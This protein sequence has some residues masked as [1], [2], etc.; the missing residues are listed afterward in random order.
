MIILKDNFIDNCKLLHH[1]ELIESDD[2]F[3]T[4]NLQNSI[5]EIQ[6][7]PLY[8]LILIY[9]NEFTI[10]SLTFPK[11]IPPK[12]YHLH[13]YNWDNP[14][15]FVSLKIE[16]QPRE[17]E[18]CFVKRTANIDSKILTNI[19]NTKTHKFVWFVLHITESNNRYLRY[20]PEF[21]MSRQYLM[22]AAF[23]IIYDTVDLFKSTIKQLEYPQIKDYN[24]NYIDEC[25]YTNYN[26]ISVDISIFIHFLSKNLKKYRN[27]YDFMG[28]SIYITS[29]EFSGI[30][31]NINYMHDENAK[32][33]ISNGPLIG[34]VAEYV[35]KY[36]EIEEYVYVNASYLICVDEKKIN[37]IKMIHKIYSKNNKTPHS[38]KFNGY[39]KIENY[40]K[41]IEQMEV[42]Q[43]YKNLL[44]AALNS[45]NYEACDEHLM[46]IKNTKTNQTF[47]IYEIMYDNTI[48]KY[49]NNDMILCCNKII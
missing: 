44:Y 46:F 26:S 28:H 35:I 21:Y 29:R 20:T 1:M 15:P 19:N 37:I 42:S 23:T 14:L 4:Y 38:V 8:G 39:Y 22:T 16:Q 6:F 36:K 45:S 32:C 12:G 48:W 3:N 33:F 30:L 24:I 41:A 34:V 2:E 17:R 11:I 25:I 5:T 49:K 10:D 43:N 40:E 13:Y 31:R 7:K 9:A 18:I 27:N 47:L